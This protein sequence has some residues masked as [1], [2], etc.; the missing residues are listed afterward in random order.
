MHVVFFLVLFA[1][2]ATA[3]FPLRGREAPPTGDRSLPI[4]P[5]GS[6]LWVPC[7]APITQQGRLLR[8]LLFIYEVTNFNS[9]HDRG[10]KAILSDIQEV[11]Q[12]QQ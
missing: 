11:L 1:V 7:S 3:A 6:P 12:Q 4:L 10:K 2:A 5:D 8:G 9:K